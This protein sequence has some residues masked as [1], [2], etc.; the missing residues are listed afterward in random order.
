MDQRTIEFQLWDQHLIPCIRL[1]LAEV[2]GISCLHHNSSVQSNHVCLQIASSC[3][4][5]PDNELLIQGSKIPCV[6]CDAAVP[7]SVAYYRA[8]YTPND[9]KS[10]DDWAA[11]H[12]IEH[13]KAIKV[14]HR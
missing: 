8:G 3:S 14:W 7:V 1:T 9:Y 10:E 2:G 13:S 11:R 4:I 12:L 6:S 5:G